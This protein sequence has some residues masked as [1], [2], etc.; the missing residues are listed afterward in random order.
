MDEKK[1]LAVL[2]AVTL[3][4]LPGDRKRKRTRLTPE[5]YPD[6]G[7]SLVTQGKANPLFKGTLRGLGYG[8][9]GAL[10]GGGAARL[11]G[12]DKQKAILASIL[13]GAAGTGLGFLS[14]KGEAQSD[15]SKLLFLR[16]MGINN[17]GELDAATEYPTLAR[18][19][20][21]KGVHI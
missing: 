11:M 8:G 2:D 17:P 5:P 6:Y 3:G 12:A 13:A 18:K 14:G 21:D 20:T 4:A 1:L 7:K 19:L 10:L 15:N 16:R 9:I